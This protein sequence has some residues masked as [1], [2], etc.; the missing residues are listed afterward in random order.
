MAHVTMPAPAVP[1]AGP[2]GRAP[3]PS[4]YRGLILFWAV[5]G[6]VVVTGAVTLQVLGPP[7]PKIDLAKLVVA[8]PRPAYYHAIPAPDPALLAPAPDFVN[9]F[10]PVKGPDG[11]TPMAV[12]AAPYDIADKHPRVALVI[13]GIGQDLD[14]SEQVLKT[15]PGAI[16]VAF[17]AYMDDDR[18]VKLAELA[19]HNGHEC[20]MSIPMEPNGF[21]T[22]DEGDRQLTDR[23]D[24]AVNKQNLEWALSRQTGCVG[25]T[26]ASDGFMGERFAQYGGGMP[27][28]LEEVG[29]RGLMYF[30]PA[31]GAPA[32]SQEPGTSIAIADTVIDQQVKPEEPVTADVIDQRLAELEARAASPG[33]AI[34]V[35]GPPQPVMLQRIAVWAHGLAARGITLVP[36]TA[37][38]P[39]VKAADQDGN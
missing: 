17:S 19:R 16:D 26:G 35:A 1:K 5:I 27:D 15:L 3:Q 6:V 21:P 36:L 12:Y 25:A 37:L 2:P 22:H 18:A 34:G 20:L 38:R 33:A 39:A 29:S 11:R 30:A 31:T 4:R 23:L 9:R 10:L 14:L 28:V 7:A 8:A 13:A 24:L 32:L